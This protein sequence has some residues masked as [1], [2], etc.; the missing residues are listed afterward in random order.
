MNTLYLRSAAKACLLTAVC[1]LVTHTLTAQ[2]GQALTE[3]GAI[4]IVPIVD[5]LEHP[6]ALAFLPDGR[7]LVT[8]RPGR[9]RIVAADS[10][11][12]APV[13]G[14]P[15]V[16]NV[17][18][19]GL[20]DVALDPDF[21]DNGYIYLSY[22]QMGE[23]SLASTAFGRGR[24]VDDRI[25]DFETLFVQE[26]KLK[27]GKHF[28]GRIEFTGEDMLYFTMG[29]RYQ[30]DPA[31]DLTNHLG[32]IV[33]LHR[34]GT[35]PD[36]NPF[37][38]AS[39]SKPEIYSYGHRN[40]QAAAINP[41]TGILWVTEMGPMGGDELNQVMA[42]KNYGW[43][44]VSWGDNYDNTKI[45][46]PTTRP[47]FTDAA[48]HWSPTISPSGMVFYT[49]AIYEAWQGNALIGGLT[50]GGIIRVA[51]DGDTAEELERIP[52]GGRV[53]EVAQAPDGTLYVLTDAENGQL[54]HLR[55]FTEDGK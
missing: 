50:A 1:L 52:I 47:E 3:A 46:D 42:G 28:G 34:D 49:G 27:G 15:E 6:W 18:Q 54:F 30:F 21:A 38:E 45:P 53:R 14:T 32:T 43:P 23:D 7:M 11:L 22:A 19:G 35:I 8:E 31:Q 36:D 55:P 10:T 33:R 17:D 20:L 48:I 39:D 5:S 37:A 29:E 4:K 2:K 51:V 13:E 16:Y 24:W 12:S 44:V 9:L 40:I 25:E 41:A 26:Y